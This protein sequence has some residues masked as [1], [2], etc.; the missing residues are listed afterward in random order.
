MAY[1]HLI[2]SWLTLHSHYRIDVCLFITYKSSLNPKI[3]FDWECAAP[4]RNQ[5]MYIC[6]KIPTISHHS[7]IHELVM[8]LIFFLCQCVALTNWKCY[9]PFKWQ[10]TY[11]LMKYG[12]FMWVNYRNFGL[13]VISHFSILETLMGLTYI[14]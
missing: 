10:Y 7:Q 12:I 11:C 14:L 3:S 6:Q 9:V 13:N 4:C 2:S 1:N 5:L 8:D